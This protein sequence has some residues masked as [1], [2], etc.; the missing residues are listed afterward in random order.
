MKKRTGTFLKRTIFKKRKEK[1]MENKKTII[2]IIIVVILIIALIT[3]SYLYS[4]FNSKQIK[5]FTEE[6]NALLQKNIATEEINSEI[7]TEK[8]YAIV[9]E[10]IKEYISKLKNIYV[11][12]NKMCSEIN[13]NDIFSAE[14]LEN[15]DVEKIDTIVAE[16]KE[17]SKNYLEEY[18]K[19]IEEEQI[20]KNIE[21]RNIKNRKNYYIDLYKTV[22]LSDSMKKQYQ[23]LEKDIDQKR[24]KLNGKL[25]NLE[26]I[27]KY[28]EENEKYWSIKDGKIQFNNINRMT[29][30]Y[31]LLNELL[32]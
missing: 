29:E 19:A 18:K 30:Y 4:M 22:M 23:I 28:L 10:S 13:P 9:E 17:K 20:L 32:D 2:G 16:Y 15:K 3:L 31:N 11:E 14:N 7:K 8:N 25:D 5:I 12:I 24:E 27:E 21:K 1:E 26:K 6:T